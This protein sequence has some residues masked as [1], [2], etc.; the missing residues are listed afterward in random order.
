MRSKPPTN[1]YG[2]TLEE[3]RAAATMGGHWD[4]EAVM[5]YGSIEAALRAFERHWEAGEDPTDWPAAFQKMSR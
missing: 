5:F 3:W 2:L 4:P 1:E